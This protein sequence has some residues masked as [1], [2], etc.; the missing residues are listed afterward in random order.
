MRAR[1]SLQLVPA[2]I[3]CVPYGFVNFSLHIYF[4]VDLFGKVWHIK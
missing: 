1:K 2:R 4:P 3:K